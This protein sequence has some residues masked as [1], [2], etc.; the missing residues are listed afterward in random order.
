MTV[1]LVL[2]PQR[3]VLVRVVSDTSS[4]N[5]SAPGSRRGGSTDHRSRGKRGAKRWSARTLRQSSAQ[6]NVRIAALV[7]IAAFAGGYAS[8][9]AT[10]V[11]V[12]VAVT[13]CSV[14][15]LLGARL[16][17]GA[18]RTNELASWI[19]LVTSIAGLAFAVT[20]ATMGR[21]EP[22]SACWAQLPTAE[23]IANL[24]RHRPPEPA[25]KGAIAFGSPRIVGICWSSRS[26]TDVP[27]FA[28]RESRGRSAPFDSRQR[29]LFP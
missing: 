2:S 26:R 7:L 8:F 10:P 9:A 18:A 4:T 13:I 28:T 20:V 3:T 19:A 16:A 17:L 25:I 1:Y 23:S 24:L 11:A 27:L 29:S 21:H 14:S 6:R 5:A 22:V 12:T 15:A